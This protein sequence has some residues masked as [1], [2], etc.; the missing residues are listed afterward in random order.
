MSR[1]RATV[2][3]YSL[4]HERVRAPRGPPLV[5]VPIAGM[6]DAPGCHPHSCQGDAVAEAEYSRK[7]SPA[8]AGL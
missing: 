1:E 8:G 7:K 2:M 3:R 4:I 5:A 6:R